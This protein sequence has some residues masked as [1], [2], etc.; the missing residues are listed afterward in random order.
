[1]ISLVSAVQVA[2][3]SLSTTTNPSSTELELPIDTSVIDTNDVD[4]TLECWARPTFSLANQAFMRSSNDWSIRRSATT[5]A[6]ELYRQNTSVV[7][8]SFNSLTSGEW[9]HIAV[10]SP[11]STRV[12]SC[13]LN[14]KTTNVQMTTNA[15]GQRRYPNNIF[16]GGNYVGS[17]RELHVWKEE[18]SQ[19]LI[20]TYKQRYFKTA[21][22]TL[23]KQFRMIDPK[24]N[25]EL[26]EYFGGRA[27]SVPSS[28]A[29]AVWVNENV[30][31]FV[32]ATD[33]Y[34][35]NDSCSTCNSQCVACTSATLNSCT[36]TKPIYL[37]RG[38]DSGT[39]DMDYGGTLTS[40]TI[41][42]WF[43]VKVWNRDNQ[44]FL[45]LNP[46][47]TAKRQ[48][49]SGSIDFINEEGQTK[50][51]VGVS[52]NVWTHLAI[53]KDTTNAIIYIDAV[54]KFNNQ[55]TTKNT[56]MRNINL[57]Q[58]ASGDSSLYFD[59]YYQD[60]RVWS[61]LRSKIQISTYMS[62]TFSS[63]FSSSLFRYYKL[64]QGTGNALPDEITGNGPSKS[65]IGK[66]WASLDCSKQSCQN[67]CST[68][69]Y[70]DSNNEC[71]ACSSTCELCSGP[72]DTQCTS[73][74]STSPYRNEEDSKCYQS[75]PTN[76]KLIEAE[77][78]C[79]KNCPTSYYV[80]G[81]TCKACNTSCL[82][83]SGSA[84]TQCLT[85]K[86]GFT[87]TSTKTCIRSC[88]TSQYVDANN[89]CQNC[90]TSCL[91][92]SGTDSTC[93]SCASPNFLSSSTCI[94][95]CPTST[96]ADS[97]R[98][99]K[100]CST[101]CQTCSGSASNEC[102]TCKTS[103]PYL[104]SGACVATCPKVVQNGTCVDSCSSGYYRDGTTCRAC[105][106]ACLECE[107][108]L[109]TNCTKCTG[110]LY[111]SQC[112]TSCPS[113][114][115]IVGKECFA[116]N[117]SCKSCTGSTAS[118][119]I[120]CADTS[121]YLNTESKQCVN[122]CTSGFYTYE[123]KK[124]CVRSCP[125][126]SYVSGSAC[127]ACNEN[128][129]TCQSSATTCTSCS[130]SLFLSDSKCASSCPSRSYIDGNVC[131]NCYST[132]LTCNGTGETDCLTCSA[133]FA[134]YDVSSKKC[135]SECPSGT[136]IEGES[137]YSSCEDGKFG[138]SSTKKCEDCSSSC[139]TC[140]DSSQTCTSCSNSFLYEGSCLSTCPDG[141]YSSTSTASCIDCNESCE[142]C[143]GGT[144]SDC[145]SCSTGFYLY[146]STTKTCVST[147]PNGTYASEGMCATC[148]TSCELCDS[149]GVCT[150]C[151]SDSFMK[152]DD[153]T[154]SS[155]CKPGEV[156]DTTKRACANYTE[157]KPTGSVS[158]SGTKSLSLTYP[159]SLVKGTGTV[160]LYR[161][162]SNVL[163]EVWSISVLNSTVAASENL[164]TVSLPANLLQNSTIYAVEVPSGAI[165]T[166]EG[167]TTEAFSRN[168]WTFTPI[169]SS[170]QALNAVLN[171][172]QKSL[173]FKTN[174]TMKLDASGSYDPNEALRTVNLEYSWNCSDFTESYLNYRTQ[175]G[176]NWGTYVSE[177]VKANDTLQK[178]CTFWDYTAKLN[179]T[180]LELKQDWAVDQVLKME[181]FMKDNS[182]QSFATIYVRFISPD[183]TEASFK[184]TFNS[185]VTA[186]RPLKLEVKLTNPNGS[187]YELGWSVI[188][189]SVPVYLTPLTGT[190]Y[191]T[192]A[193]N[194]LEVGGSYTFTLSYTDSLSSV[195]AVLVVQVNTPPTGGL[196]S[197]DKTTGLALMSSLKGRM[198][199][200]T[201][202][203]LPLAYSYSYSTRTSTP[204]VSQAIGGEQVS[205]F[206]LSSQQSS[207]EFSLTFPSEAKMLIGYCTDAYGSSAVVRQTVKLEPIEDLVRAKDKANAIE[208]PSSFDT[209]IKAVSEV[210][211]ISAEMSLF[212]S[213]S[214]ADA[215]SIKTKLIQALQAALNQA[216]TLYFN[217]KRE[218]SAILYSSILSA[219]EPTSRQP[220]SKDNLAS[221]LSLANSTDV[222]RLNT[223]DEVTLSLSNST[224][225]TSQEVLST[226]NV[227]NVAQNVAKA[228]TNAISNPAAS[229]YISLINSLASKANRVLGL[230]S[231][232]TENS[233]VLNVTDYNAYSRRDRVS[234]FENS[235]L[236]FENTVK[237]AIP[238]LNLTQ[239]TVLLEAS[240][241]KSSMVES[242]RFYNLGTTLQLSIKDA[243]S[244]QEIEI[245]SLTKP[246]LFDFNFTNQDYSRLTLEIGEDFGG[247]RQIWPE[248][249]YLN[250]TTETWETEGCSL[251]N[252]AEA[253]TYFSSRVTQ[254]VSI[255]CACTHLSEFSVGFRP[256]A[257]AQLSSYIIRDD[258][259]DDFTFSDWED[260]IVLYIFLI[261]GISYFLSMSFAY[262][263]D[264]FNPSYGLPS[265]EAERVHNFFDPEKVETVLKQLESAYVK[266]LMD[267]NKPNDPSDYVV[268]ISNSGLVRKLKD[269]YEKADNAVA[270]SSFRE[271]ASISPIRR[272]MTQHDEIFKSS[273]SSSDYLSSKSSVE[274]P[275]AEKRTLNEKLK[276]FLDKPVDDVR[277]NI[278]LPGDTG[279]TELVAT[280]QNIKHT[281]ENL[282][283]RLYLL[284]NRFEYPSTVDEFLGTYDSCS[285]LPKDVQERY[286]LKERELKLQDILQLGYSLEDDFE[287]LRMIGANVSPD[288]YMLTG[289]RY[290][291]K[292]I[293]DVDEFYLT[294]KVSFTTLFSL[295]FKKEH[296]VMALFY[297]LHLEYTKKAMLS[298]L[299]LH[300][301]LQLLFVQLYIHYYDF[302]FDRYYDPNT[303]VCVW[304]CIREGQIIAGF[305]C[306]S[307]PWP[308]VYL[309]KYLIARNSIEYGATKQWVYQ[310]TLNKRCRLLLGVL[311]CL[312]LMVA[313]SLAIVLMSY[314]YP[315]SY[316]EARDF[317]VCFCASLVWSIVI[318]ELISIALKALVVWCAASED[319]NLSSRGPMSCHA[320]FGRNL[321]A[322]F[323]CLLPTEL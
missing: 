187:K 112:Y 5:S 102:L 273:S 63:P 228:L 147:C 150:Q 295:Y 173:E 272:L 286:K 92:C 46:V 190:S 105:N 266:Q 55:F 59:G 149:K 103:T 72:A 93:T 122:F 308:F 16:I 293:E 109:S 128:C 101:N 248:C 166:T 56:A 312:S 17:V 74:L 319:F 22:S 290:A 220:L 113:A 155:S 205:E 217:G 258:D 139:L 214:S 250:P 253:Y 239:T 42:L 163:S 162:D 194:S 182:R 305:V 232:I 80:D 137:C 48:Q 237:V 270:T 301:L 176:V 8:C 186:D 245:K 104:S 195:S 118:D 66:M 164:F 33:E 51:T 84:A 193:E 263:W 304:G 264:N 114:T 135:V 151:V 184:S 277:F 39:L 43:M 183:S 175:R 120:D 141:S 209:S 235:S 219:Y 317:V 32:C 240:V 288:P 181:F 233:R 69:Y 167:Y 138:N 287:A 28:I 161:S 170:L 292:L 47:L 218:Q 117:A 269:T 152:S 119:C 208:T 247:F 318:G 123:A 79:V 146:T 225:T 212:N 260:G 284:N 58:I 215:T 10:V 268:R 44:Q 211:S 276:F 2:L 242:S 231:Q 6:L 315:Y 78:L 256:V 204:T 316:S 70:K 297:S 11:Q 19:L 201:D 52:S 144:S 207:S 313:S 281:I 255:Q 224:F 98:A 65:L 251:S 172:S 300:T 221:L 27:G 216:S 18:R 116:C 40:F 71:K 229:S 322:Y 26:A 31:E 85:C 160:K 7:Y 4:Y 274:P 140:K 60:L 267:T 222:S 25:T 283:H 243:S 38:V 100:A 129:L 148:G 156:R 121:P 86:S 14:G 291:K 223:F 306:A 275:V 77:S 50:L 179:S 213:S 54:E 202:E 88:E 199:S 241:Y 169:T 271:V 185:K 45:Y 96:Y 21:P 180:K 89:A 133:S 108:S 131:K 188:G 143:T 210:A 127:L 191:L 82:T 3:I 61:S 296:K 246:F 142:T 252:I 314:Y 230:N 145:A 206:I 106:S 57:G 189:P 91:T 303:D 49:S 265:I 323:P 125:S 41:E 254:D 178:T 126:S 35:N 226:L 97:S 289:G 249:T 261:L 115:Y 236:A 310:G 200:W 73:C 321:L 311:M 294:L 30:S 157:K 1:L 76:T 90:S 111:K 83:C 238:T 153:K 34:F 136:Y 282:Q 130:S 95:A 134:Y 53:V 309:V 124:Q 278:K 62:S 94:S 132:C 279:Q 171:G 37:Y 36:E 192:I 280:P 154:C 68:K 12:F 257:S 198:L 302:S 227:V 158:L 87:I 320:E 177:Y 174:D 67:L 299:F 307:F 20:D 262:Y 75:C 244:D 64:T 81:T 110:Y 13:Y 168:D 23:H 285:R 298:F 196:F 203:D 99:C 197:V 15:E 29:T 234:K 9:F 107:G 165:K 159:Y 24:T 259:D